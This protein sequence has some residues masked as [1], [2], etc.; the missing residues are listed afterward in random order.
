VVRVGTS[1]G[2]AMVDS[3]NLWGFLSR[4]GVLEGH[5]QGV[6]ADI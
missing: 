4:F 6:D 1:E 5:G 2:D 3:S